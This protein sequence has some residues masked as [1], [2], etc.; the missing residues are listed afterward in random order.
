MIALQQWPV[1]KAVSDVERME[2]CYHSDHSYEGGNVPLLLKKKSKNRTRHVKNV[3]T[4]LDLNGSVDQAYE[5]AAMDENQPYLICIVIWLQKKLEK[6]PEAIVTGRDYFKLFLK[7]RVE[8]K[9]WMGC[10]L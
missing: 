3:E 10:L 4:A 1:L 7:E 2:S 9:M 6:N 5:V 8:L